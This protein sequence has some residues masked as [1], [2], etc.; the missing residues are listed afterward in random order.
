MRVLHILNTSTFSGAENVVCQIISMFREDDDIQMIY[1]SRDGNIRD[2]LAE[3]NIMFEPIMDMTVS[4]L[5]KVIKKT[6]PDII[7][8]HDMKAGYVASKACGKIPLISHIHNNAYDSRGISVK[9]I[10]YTFAAKKAKHIFWVSNSSFEGYVF[11]FFFKK[12]SSILYN[13][14]SI[15]SSISP[16]PI[17]AIL[18]PL[19]FSTTSFKIS[20]NL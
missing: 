8:A 1:C 11:H 3:K 20:S 2:T 7:H 16:V 19:L 18:V 9:A 6:N 14:I 5:K 10:A 13:I 15:S 17:I 4:E 12:K